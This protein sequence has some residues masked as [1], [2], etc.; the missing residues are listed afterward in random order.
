R[1]PV[2][3]MCPSAPSEPQSP[4]SPWKGEG[5]GGDRDPLP[6]ASPRRCAFEQAH[7][8][9]VRGLG[10]ILVMLAHGE[11]RLGRGQAHYFVGFR[12]ERLERVGGRDRQRQ[13][14]VSPPAGRC[15]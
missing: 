13:A 2:K 6:A 4:P 8:L 11:E 3:A 1:L 5:W 10:K 15:R 14:P 12:G 7:H 9:L